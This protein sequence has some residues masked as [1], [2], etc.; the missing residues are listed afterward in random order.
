MGKKTFKRSKRGK[1]RYSKKFTRNNKRLTSTLRVKLRKTGTQP[2]TATS[3]PNSQTFKLNE[4]ASYQKFTDMYEQYRITEIKQT[5]YP[6]I[7]IGQAPSQTVGTIDVDVVDLDNIGVIYEMLLGA[8]I[9]RDDI[10]PLSNL[11]DCLKNPS[12]KIYNLGRGKPITIRW[13]PNIVTSTSTEDNKVVV[14]D[15]WLDTEDSSDEL[16]MGLC[17]LYHVNG[18]SAS[19]PVNYRIL[20]TI[21]CEFKRFRLDE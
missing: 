11:E 1:G 12:I 7:Q 21:T 4:F 20:T 18:A 14:Y 5:I 19:Y 10:S 15:R 13:K 16:Y 6:T 2:C 8:K 9:D 3:T 17:K